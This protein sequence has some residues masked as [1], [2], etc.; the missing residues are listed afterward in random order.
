MLVMQVLDDRCGGKSN[1]GR[2]AIQWRKPPADRCDTDS[3]RCLSVD[4]ECN[5][6]LKASVL[7]TLATAYL[8]YGA[9]DQ[10][11]SA[12]EDAL[13]IKEYLYEERHPIVAATQVHL[14]T[15]LRQASKLDQALREVNKA[16]KTIEF[17]LGADNVTYADA[18]LERGL[19]HLDAHRLNEAR[20][21][22]ARSA[23]LFG[24][25]GDRRKLLALD[26]Q[27]RIIE[28]A[29]SKNRAKLAEARR[30]YEVIFQSDLPNDHPWTPALLHN[31]GTI[32]HA[33]GEYAAARSNFDRAIGNWSCAC[34]ARPSAIDAYVNR[35]RAQRELKDFKAAKADVGMALRLDRKIRGHRHP[36]VAYDLVSLAKL[37]AQ[38]GAEGHEEAAIRYLDEAID[39]YVSNGYQHHAYLELAYRQRYQLSQQSTD[40]DEADRIS[41]S[42]AKTNAAPTPNQ[43]S[44]G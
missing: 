20:A 19:I 5:P 34:D 23:A 27:A 16:I 30:I 4:L 36:C 24:A 22:A 28:V 12:L 35:G 11:V 1:A 14:A 39:I 21:D 9:F 40:K 41:A 7:E 26:L 29:E 3:E 6:E 38:E 18:L 42:V 15:A 43:W 32:L 10:A 8:E 25:K 17:F 33:L 37:L 44:T 31:E 13:A 2:L